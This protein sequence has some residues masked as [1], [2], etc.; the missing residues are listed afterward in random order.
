MS[1][2]DTDP[3]RTASRGRPV[4]SG[5]PWRE[6]FPV[7]GGYADAPFGLVVVDS[8]RRAS[9]VVAGIQVHRGGAANASFAAV[10]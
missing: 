6:S 1:T 3:M 9:P 8:S 4:L 5:A 7:L 2:H 10:F